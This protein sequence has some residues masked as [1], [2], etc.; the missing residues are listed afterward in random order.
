MSP[1][2]GVGGTKVTLKGTNFGGTTAVK[3]N[4]TNASSFTVKGTTQISAVVPPTATTGVVVVTNAGGDSTT[5][6]TFTILPPQITKIKPSHGPIGQPVTFSGKN[7]VGVS[8][9][10][11]NATAA[12]EFHFKGKTLIATVGAGTT[13][14]AVH[15]TT[16]GGNANGPPVFTVDPSPVP[17][18]KSFKPTSGHVGATVTISGTGFYGTSS[19]TINGTGC[20]SVVI[21]ASNKLTCVVGGG[22]TTG[23]ITVTTPGGPATSTGSF[24]VLP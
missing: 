15:V 3:F 21:L 8:A 22:T 6:G 9:V 23:M 14:G 4:G 10:A 17:T 20:G 13:S 2:D 7:L 12:S 24:T 5:G 19:V 11:F 18:I 16:P 1:T